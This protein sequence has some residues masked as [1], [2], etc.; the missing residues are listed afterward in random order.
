[1]ESGIKAR[2][3]PATEMVLSQMPND[4]QI[5]RNGQPFSGVE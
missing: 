3:L 2:N 4:S 1:M 5:Q